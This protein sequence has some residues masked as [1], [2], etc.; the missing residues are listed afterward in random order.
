MVW[1][2][3]G[4]LIFFFFS[5]EMFSI[6]DS[7]AY[8]N[9]TPIFCKVFFFLC[10]I[11]VTSFQEMEFMREKK[12]NDDE[13]DRTQSSKYNESKR[14][15]KSAASETNERKTDCHR[16]F[17]F[18][19]KVWYIFLRGIVC[20]WYIGYVKYNCKQTCNLPRLQSVPWSLFILKK[21]DRVRH[22]E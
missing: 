3:G 8:V 6:H 11:V 10:L 1:G 7:P 14:Q 17:I 20:K 9:F 2:W 21:K 4:N 18:F 22:L 19:S 13:H 15:M 5:S 12:A 16:I